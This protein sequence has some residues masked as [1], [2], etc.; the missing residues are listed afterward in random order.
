MQVTVALRGRFHGFRL[1][2]ELDRRG[3]LARL[4]TSYPAR[5][6]SGWGVARPRIVSLPHWEAALRGASRLPRRVQEALDPHA[7][8]GAGFDAQ[9][10]RRLREGEQDLFVGWSSMALRCLR[11]AR[12]LGIPGVLERGSSHIAFQ[13]E[14]LGEEYRRHGVRADLAS[15]RIIE[16][17][18]R[19][20]EEADRIAVPSGFARRTFVE[21]G[22]DES[23]IIV[24][25]YGVDLEAFHPA[26]SSERTFRLIHCGALSLR[27][28]VH[29]LLQAFHE[30]ALPDAELWLV[31]G[32][33]EEIRPFLARHAGAGVVVPGP[34][35]ERELPD[36]YRSGSAFCLASLEDGF[37]MV[38]L[39]AMASGLPVIGSMHTGAPDVV[40]DGEDGFLVP[41][42]D[43][44]A[45]KEKILYLYENPE[46]RQ[47]MGAAA[48][49]RVRMGHG[50][51]DYGRRAVE[52]YARIL[53]CPSPS[54]ISGH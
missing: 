42:R 18:L 3:C 45:L 26:P 36:L 31:G 23:R 9:A 53:S 22:M 46:A 47:A 39:Q 15:P 20:Y 52:A 7:R 33:R 19:E 50:W 30:L 40:R 43:V 2:H 34:R 13:T 12:E 29:Y 25:P 44:D 14:L 32:V 28:G 54:S 41:P 11:R 49:E 38:I 5:V 37:G 8:V 21:R 4:I 6:A 48:R 35:P 27:K 24:N 10:A 51:D 16:A 17:E 1:A